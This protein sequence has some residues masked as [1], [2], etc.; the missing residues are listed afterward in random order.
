MKI[1][2]ETKTGILVV[3][4]L[5]VLAGLLLKVG[6]FNPF[7]KGYTV[8]SRFHFTGGVKKHA[9]VCLSGVEVG[10]VK[11]IRILYGDDTQVEL[12]LWLENGVKL[13]SDSAAYATTLGLMGEKYIEIK[14]GAQGE[15]VKDGDLIVGKDPMRLEDLME[16]GTKAVAHIGEAA[17]N[18]NGVIVDNRPKID[19]IFT[20]LDET[21]DNFREFS[22]DVKYHPWKVLMKGKE[23]PKE[24]REKERTLRRQSVQGQS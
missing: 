13:R 8:R 3:V 11:D 21:S 16:T 22:D 17:K 20:N 2:D 24:Q 9:P 10:E 15:A 4:C 1:T 23:V 7:E 14:P 18:V 5:A 12:D 19:N 6:N